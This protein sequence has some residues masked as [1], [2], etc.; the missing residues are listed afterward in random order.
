LANHAP[1]H[2]DF[3]HNAFVYEDDSDYVERS[4]TF[5]REGLEAGDA[6]VAAGTRDRLALIREGLGADA[7][8]A[9][10]VDVSSSYTR[11]ARTLAGYYGTVLEVLR[12]APRARLVAEVQYGPA[13]AEWDEWMAYEALFNVSFHHLPAWTLCSYDGSKTPDRVIE[14]VW[15][16]HPEVLAGGWCD[17]EHF[18]DV[19]SMVRARIRPPRELPELRSLPGADDP[20]AVRETLARELGAAGVPD[21]RALDMLVVANEVARNAFEYGG[22]VAG[23][24]TGQVD[25]RFVLEVVDRGA[26]FDDP[27]A[28]YVAPRTTEPG[29]PG[30]A[31]LWVARQLAWRVENFQSPDGHTV[32]VWL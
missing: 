18:E 32:R 25:G 17:S 22:G 19:A 11:P 3:R 24:R 26:G 2:D 6:P 14:D 31:G 8:H 7:Q 13:A 4:T 15:R 10:F 1:K 27:L 9:T 23:L 28:G 21:E 29:E 12:K 30:P 16:T 20:T 5:L